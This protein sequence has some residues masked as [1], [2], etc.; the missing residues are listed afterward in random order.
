LNHFCGFEILRRNLS[1]FRRVAPSV[2][3]ANKISNFARRV[4][5]TTKIR[6]VALHGIQRGNNGGMSTPRAVPPNVVEG[7]WDIP[8]GHIPSGHIP[9]G[10]YSE[11]RVHPECRSPIPKK[12]DLVART[13]IGARRLECV[14]ETVFSKGLDRRPG[15]SYHGQRSDLLHGLQS[16]GFVG[17]NFD[18][19][20]DLHDFEDFGHIFGDAAKR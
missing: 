8:S 15:P 1:M 18:Q 16:A 5:G 12:R 10:V 11:Y 7:D 14:D 4:P 20:I 9:S 17:V 19:L 13:S 2:T 3:W 6:W